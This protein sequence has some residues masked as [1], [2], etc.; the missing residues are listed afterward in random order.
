VDELR[1]SGY[2]PRQVY[3]ENAELRLALD[4][5]RTGF[6]SP[7]DTARYGDIFHTLVDWGD[8]YL[9]LADYSAFVEAQE[10]A[11]QRF[12]DVPAWTGS[13]IENVAGMG[14]FSS[15]R[16]IAEYARDI[17]HVQSIQME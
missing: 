13:A 9:V 4:Q 2:R 14:K 11:D 7:G 16:A 17:W 3:E 15:D 1:S 10:A 6:Y 12:I 8:H 5:I